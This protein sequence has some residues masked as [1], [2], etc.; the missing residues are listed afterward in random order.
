MALQGEAFARDPPDGLI[1]SRSLMQPLGPCLEAAPP[2]APAPPVWPTGRGSAAAAA[3]A[4]NVA[5]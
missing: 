5:L 3:D 1:S 2:P 4:F